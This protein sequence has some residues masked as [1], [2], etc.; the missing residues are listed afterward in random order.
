MVSVTPEFAALIQMK[1][2]PIYWRRLFELFVTSA[3]SRFTFTPY[4]T[5]DIKN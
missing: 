2:A 5:S 3:I 1:E 4:S